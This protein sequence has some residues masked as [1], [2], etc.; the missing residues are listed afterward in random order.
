[1]IIHFMA[2]PVSAK[3]FVEP[4][5]DA[6]NGRG[7]RAELWV[8]QTFNANEFFVGIHCPKK[9]VGFNLWFHPIRNIRNLMGTLSALKAG[10]VNVV[11]AHQTRSAFLPLVAATILGVKTRIY[12][13][14]GSAFRAATGVVR[15]GFWLIE[16]FLCLLATQVFFV[17]EELRRD[18]VRAGLVSEEKGRVIGP[19]SACGIDLDEYRA[20]DFCPDAKK[21]QRK[22][23]GLSENTFVVLYIG[24]PYKRKG[25]EFLLKY[26]SRHHQQFDDGRLIFAGCH[27]EDVER[28][29]GRS[30]PPSITALGYVTDL[31]P[32]LSA[33]DVV[34]LPSEHEGFCY[35][36][37]EAFAARR[38][39]VVSD[40][41]GLRTQI[42]DG[43]TG[44]LFSTGSED[45]FHVQMLTV[46][47]SP[48]LREALGN[49]A[50]IVAENYS[51]TRVVRE[52]VKT[53][54]NLVGEARASTPRGT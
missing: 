2:N 46:Y 51:R 1:M 27:R 40:A 26:W 24:R 53:I 23:L 20:A 19:G 10:D 39:V 43:R 47:E 38:C 9:R 34:V 42:A 54:V 7:L 36:I 21:L 41:P 15:L 30:Y 49:E 37:L 48:A 16:K 32:H 5:V 6:L 33:C 12:H 18:F 45:E 50:R 11:H 8:D 14:H 28:I 25:F 22:R 31:R 13:N 29:L 3:R 35:A 52:F 44:L 17:S 4:L